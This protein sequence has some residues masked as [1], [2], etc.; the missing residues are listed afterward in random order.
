MTGKPE[1]TVLRDSGSGRFIS[2]RQAASKPPA[3][4]Q[5]EQV[6]VKNPKPHARG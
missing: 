5:K 3:T 1:K 2:K 4:W 6:P